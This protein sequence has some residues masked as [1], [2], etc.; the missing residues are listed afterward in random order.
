MGAYLIK[1]Y[2]I[3]LAKRNKSLQLSSYIYIY[4]T[5]Q[6]FTLVIKSQQERVNI[7]NSLHQIL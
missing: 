5:F 7:Q 1:G 3:K 4:T 6:M 2:K